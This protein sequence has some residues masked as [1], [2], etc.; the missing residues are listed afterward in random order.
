MLWL[1]GGPTT[2]HLDHSWVYVQKCRKGSRGAL[3]SAKRAGEDDDLIPRGGR[4]AGGVVAVACAGNEFAAA[5]RG[6]HFHG[7]G[8]EGA[9]TARVGGIVGQR[10]LIANIVSDLL[11]NV[12][13]ILDVF[14]EIGQPAG[15]NRDL[16]KGPP[17]ALGVLF[18]FLAEQ[19]NRVDYGGGFLNFANG[20]FQRIMAGIVFAISNDKKNALVLGSFFQVIE[21]ANDGV[22]EGGAAA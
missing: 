4:A 10:V 13:H 1:R 16:F 22:I 15:G 12:V 11:A 21:G 5:T 17:G 20:F 7:D 9:V 6:D 2:A 8:A 18:A 19:A 3:S 14:R